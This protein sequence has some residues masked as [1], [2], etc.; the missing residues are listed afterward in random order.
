MQSHGV[1]FAK[2]KSDGPAPAFDIGFVTDDVE[3]A[4]S[5]AIA[6]GATEVAPPEQKP[7]GQTVSYVRDINGFLVGINSPM[8][9]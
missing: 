7:W 4:Y 3:A 9:G 8:G 6:A 5:R 1:E 2:P